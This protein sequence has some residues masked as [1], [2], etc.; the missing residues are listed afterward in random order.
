[1]ILRNPY[2]AAHPVHGSSRLENTKRCTLNTTRKHTALQPGTDDP[3]KIYCTI[4]CSRH[5]IARYPASRVIREKFHIW[6]R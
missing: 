2:G 3:T 5:I 1:M 4:K 6:E